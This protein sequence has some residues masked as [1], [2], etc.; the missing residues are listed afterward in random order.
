M[1][2][3]Y[4]KLLTLIILTMIAA[5]LA[6]SG[7]TQQPK[8]LIINGLKEDAGYVLQSDSLE[9]L[10]N[11]PGGISDRDVQ[12]MKATKERAEKA[13]QKIKQLLDANTPESEPVAL[14]EYKTTLGELSEQ[15]L[16]MHRDAS[17][18]VLMSELYQTGMGASAWL[19][20]LGAGKK[21]AGDSLDAVV[22]QGKRLQKAVSEAQKL[23]FPE[24]Y[25]QTLRGQEYTLAQLKEMADYVTIAGDERQKA[26]AAERA[27]K[28]APFLKV[29]TGDRLRIFKEE[30][31]RLGG[32][33]L[34]MGPGGAALTTPEQM[35]N[36]PVW[37][38]YG[39]NRG[40]VDTWHITGFRFQGD[41]LVGRVSKSGYGLKPP[42]SSFR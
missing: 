25:K 20:D 13:L 14:G 36:A 32:E 19:E 12:S 2:P 42:S 34:C 3:A 38:T 22:F 23:G 16:A 4:A 29:L 11:Q 30:F 39:N 9:K 41:R 1:K 33:W 31:A 35:K 40:L 7:Q 24:N 17:V 18:V 28:D 10:M 8:F 5:A 6:A 26:L 27:A 37:Y 15:I 21:L